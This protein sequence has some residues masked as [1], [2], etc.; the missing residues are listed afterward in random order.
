[1]TAQPTPRTPPRILHQR[2]EAECELV[3]IH[4]HPRNARR[5]DEEFIAESI[6]INGFWGAMV[7][8]E[9][10]RDVLVGNHRYRM[11]G[12]AGAFVGP[13]LWVTPDDD[14]H[15]TRIM[16]ADNAG[17]DR[18]RNDLT[19]LAELLNEAK[20][21]PMGLKGTGYSDDGLALLLKELALPKSGDSDGESGGT[22][23]PNLQARF[24]V[25][26]FSVLDARAGY[27]QTRKREWIALGIRGE[28]G[29]GDSLI[30]STEATDVTE[31]E[32][33]IP[34]GGELWVELRAHLRER[35]TASKLS[36]K[37]VN[38]ALGVAGMASHW[39]GT[40]QPELPTPDQWAKLAPLLALDPKY[41]ELMT[42][43]VTRPAA[44]MTHRMAAHQQRSPAHVHAA[45]SGDGGLSEALAPR[46]G[47]R[48]G[49]KGA[50]APAQPFGESYKGGDAWRG[51]RRPEE[52]AHAHKSQARLAALMKTG[53]STI[54]SETASTSGSSMFDPV[55]C[56][57]MLRWFCPKGG[58]VLDCFAGGPT[59]G[60][61]A[62]KLGYEFTGVEVRPEQIAASEAQAKALGLAPRYVLGDSTKI[63]PEMPGG[64]FD[65]VFTDPPYFNLEFYSADQSNGS[66]KKTYAEFREWYSSVLTRAASVLKDDRFM[67]VKI[68]E[69]RDAQGAYVNIVGDTAAILMEAGL[70]YYNEAILITAIGSLPVRAGR[71][72]ER[73]RKLGKAHQNCL[74]FLKGNVT[75]AVAALGDISDM[76]WAKPLMTEDSIDDP[77]LPLEE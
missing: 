63:D 9:R 54:G 69:A 49:G 13:V 68:G 58:R 38:E 32:T 56:E 8:D 37:K 44:E 72:F 52:A 14:A 28:V 53:D 16:L 19:V 48:P 43:T 47:L 39:F 36:Q 67:V 57:L 7:V 25:P 5:G 10:N 27:W 55:L 74:V 40:S 12:R 42:K 24:G 15:A 17:A 1:M 46:S 76:E 3:T 65:L 18:A 23:G 41:L 51:Q 34:E 26:P 71:P 70:V 11:L 30:Y 2:F 75:R 20:A 62:S 66:A 4:E 31:R 64:L 33:E 77:E 61:V 21:T 35:L 29:R 22:A 73:T 50:N 59:L 60:I 6:E 45:A